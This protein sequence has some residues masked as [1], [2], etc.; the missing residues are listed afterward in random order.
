[1]NATI[2]KGERSKLLAVVAIMAMVVCAFAVALPAT[3]AAEGDA[4]YSVTDT[5]GL[6]DALDTATDG[7][8]IELG[9]G[10]YGNVDVVDASNKIY[11]D[12]N[13]YMSILV[14]TPVTIRAAV[15]ATEAKHGGAA[16]F[17]K[18]GVTLQS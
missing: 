2:M 1:M 7:Q 3:D 13:G 9:T 5:E 4:D 8:I 18:S 10:T 12:S 17:T 15:D 14:D 11:F 6:L 16:R